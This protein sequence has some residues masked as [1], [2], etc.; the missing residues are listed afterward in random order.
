MLMDFV[1]TE[2]TKSY[3]SVEE[4]EESPASISLSQ[5]LDRL[6]SSEARR[7]LG[8]RLAP[9]GNE[10]ADFNYLRSVE[11]KMTYDGLLSP[12]VGN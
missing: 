11:A 6:L 10:I 4:E 7:T 8:I 12:E 3:A 5:I 9:D 2:G 1:W